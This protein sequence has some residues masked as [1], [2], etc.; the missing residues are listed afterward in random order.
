MDLLDSILEITMQEADSSWLS[1]EYAD[2]LKNQEKIRYDLPRVTSY[3]ALI[4]LHSLSFS[5]FSL[6]LAI[7]IFHPSHLFSPLF[8]HTLINFFLYFIIYF[9]VDKN[10]LIELDHSNISLES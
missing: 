6:F 9:F 10:L 5:V 4:L 8:T 1:K 3:M 7:P 2:I